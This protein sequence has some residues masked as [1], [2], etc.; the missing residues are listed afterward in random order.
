MYSTY[1]S[2][3]DGFYTVF[4][5]VAIEVELLLDVYWFVVDICDDLAIYAF[6]YMD[7]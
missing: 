3:R 4:V 2:V 7:V 6:F 1:W 5:V